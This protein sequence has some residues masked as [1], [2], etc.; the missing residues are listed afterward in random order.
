MTPRR[1][2]RPRRAK[3]GKGGSKTSDE[4][5]ATEQ[6]GKTVPK[7]SSQGPDSGIAG[8]N[9]VAAN[10]DT[11]SGRPTKRPR[12][13]V[14]SSKIVDKTAETSLPVTTPGTGK[15]VAGRDDV[16]TNGPDE[17]D[18]D[19]KGDGGTADDS[20]AKER[21]AQTALTN[22]TQGTG[23][24][25]AGR[26]D[27]AGNGPEEI[28]QNGKTNGSA[29]EVSGTTRREGETDRI[30][31]SQDSGEGVSGAATSLVVKRRRSSESAT[32]LALTRMVLRWRRRRP[33]LISWPIRKVLLRV[34]AEMRVP[35]PT[36]TRRAM[37]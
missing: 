23:E 30:D 1:K 36:A 2:A 7:T 29:A 14:P 19:S 20:G 10:V 11:K 4:A 9:D 17:I 26:N 34:S 37:V 3:A 24:S 35:R 32:A 21:A 18:E 12:P 15:G 33:R 31:S 13:D 16:A 5:V 6:S 22:T 28:G 8:G 25:V 27:V